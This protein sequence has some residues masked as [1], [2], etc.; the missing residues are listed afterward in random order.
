ME[1]YFKTGQE[2]KYKLS[3]YLKLP[4]KML[5]CTIVSKESVIARTKYFMEI[6]GD[7]EL[8]IETYV[9]FLM[10]FQSF[11]GKYDETAE[12]NFSPFNRWMAAAFVVPSIVTLA[13]YLLYANS[14]LFI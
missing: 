3:E 7:A 5:N 11:G 2:K 13:I 10:Q 9:V 1:K 12:P 6:L 8:D 14:N 4:Y